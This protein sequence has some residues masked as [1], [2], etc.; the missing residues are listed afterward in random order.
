[1]EALIERNNGTG[2]SE[3]NLIYLADITK[4]CFGTDNRPNLHVYYQC[5]VWYSQCTRLIL[6]KFAW[7]SLSTSVILLKF[8]FVQSINLMLNQTS[9]CFGT[10]SLLI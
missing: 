3:K 7:Y 4:V 10:V 9:A 1:M 5:L 2:H 6:R 8:A